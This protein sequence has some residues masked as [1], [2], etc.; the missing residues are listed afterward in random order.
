[1]AKEIIIRTIGSVIVAVIFEKVVSVGFW[2]CCIRV[3]V[4]VSIVMGGEGELFIKVYWFSFI[5]IGN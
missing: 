1:M 4:V 2:I 3:R 5:W